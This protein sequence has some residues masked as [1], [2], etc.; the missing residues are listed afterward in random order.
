M[1]LC[2]N[3]LKTILEIIPSEIIFLCVARRLEIYGGSSIYVS[4]PSADMTQS[5]S[6]ANVADHGVN[7][8]A[9][10]RCFLIRLTKDQEC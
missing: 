1:T 5:R 4:Y 2:F 7:I 8:S 6:W 10:T 9:A 3:L